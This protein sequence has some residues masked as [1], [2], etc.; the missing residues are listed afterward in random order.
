MNNFSK[1]DIVSYITNEKFR[2]T[3]EIYQDILQKV[4][5]QRWNLFYN[6]TFLNIKI[7]MN[8]TLKLLNKLSYHIIMSFKYNLNTGI[9]EYVNNSIKCIKIITFGY[10]SFYHF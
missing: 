10:R 9:I 4:K 2:T 8:T 7:Y 6:I 5:K 1:K 3:H